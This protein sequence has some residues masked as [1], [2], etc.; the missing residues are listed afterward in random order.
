MA[1]KQKK[2]RTE[3]ERDSFFSFDRTFEAPLLAGAASA[4]FGV[5]NEGVSERLTG[6]WGLQRPPE[7]TVNSIALSRFFFFH[8]L[9]EEARMEKERRQSACRVP[10]SLSRLA[11]LVRSKAFETGKGERRAR[12]EKARVL[13]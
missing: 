1:R 11:R 7:G 6:L 2:K 3:R 12:G 10:A 8:F 9:T 13:V 5:A 4:S